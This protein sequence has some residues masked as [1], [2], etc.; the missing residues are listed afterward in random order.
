MTSSDQQFINRMKQ[1]TGREVEKA[2][3]RC[4]NCEGAGFAIWEPICTACAGEGV[5]DEWVY[6]DCNCPVEVDENRD[7][8]C[9]LCFPESMELEAAA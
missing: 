7:Q 4:S 3:V 8:D 6:S 2:S 5:T 9:E 1:E